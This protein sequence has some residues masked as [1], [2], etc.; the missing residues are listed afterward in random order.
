MK[1][2]IEVTTWKDSYGNTYHTTRL[3]SIEFI[4][5]EENRTQATASTK[6][7]ADCVYGDGDYGIRIAAGQLGI[8]SR[9]ATQNLLSYGYTFA[10]R[11]VRLQKD[12]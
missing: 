12:L 10:I 3:H 11:R 1:G 4:P 7:L 2:H 9:W 5:A 8:P 6:I